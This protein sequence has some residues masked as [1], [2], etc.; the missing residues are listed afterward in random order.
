L[1][2]FVSVTALGWFLIVVTYYETLI[3]PFWGYLKSKQLLMSGLLQLILTI[4]CALFLC[5]RTIA[6]ECDADSYS[7]FWDPRFCNPY[8]SVGSMPINAAIV[9]MIIPILS[10]TV[11]QE[12]RFYVIASCWL[13]VMASLLFCCFYLHS[14]LPLSHTV[15]YLVWSPLVIFEI[16]RQSFEKFLTTKKLEDAISEI[17]RMAEAERANEMR[18]MIANVAHDLKTVRNISFSFKYMFI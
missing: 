14:H 17:H 7:T 18:H 11:L 16:M 3:S 2:L 5:A 4:L 1:I 10:A 15:L 6:G 9:L 13:I 8:A 12:T